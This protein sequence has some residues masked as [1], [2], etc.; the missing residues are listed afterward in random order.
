MAATFLISM[1]GKW[2]K[3]LLKTENLKFYYIYL[4]FKHSSSGYNTV[5]NVMVEFSDDALQNLSRNWF[6][7]LIDLLLGT[8]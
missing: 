7:D 2:N 1:I 5:S 3:N 6:D 8:W 4:L